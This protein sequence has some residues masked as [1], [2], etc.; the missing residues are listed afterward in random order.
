MEFVR[1]NLLVVMTT[2]GVPLRMF[3]LANRFFQMFHGFPEALAGQ[4]S[5]RATGVTLM[6]AAAVWVSFD[7]LCVFSRC[8]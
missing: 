4:N 6:A 3:Q 7:T 8:R 2:I 5:H 1:L